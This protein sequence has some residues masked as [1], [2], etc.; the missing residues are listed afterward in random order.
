MF[1]PEITSWKPILLRSMSKWAMLI[2]PLAATNV[3]P[4]TMFKPDP[5]ELHGAL[6]QQN[7]DGAVRVLKHS[8]QTLPDGPPDIPQSALHQGEVFLSV[9]GID[10]DWAGHHQQ[11]KDWY[12][13]G[14]P[15]GANW[16]RPVL[17]VHEGDRPG[18]ADI[19]R[20]FRN[21]FL[22]KGLQAGLGT[23]EAVKRRPTKTTPRSRRST[24]RF[25]SRWPLA[26]RSP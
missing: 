14:F 18:M 10:Q 17:G 4:R 13:A 19:G 11:I 20:V 23:P 1:S 3:P 22:L 25:A 24:T 7:P 5:V 9:N 16:D 12:H 21:T 26:A 2:R 6:F 8:G 15:N